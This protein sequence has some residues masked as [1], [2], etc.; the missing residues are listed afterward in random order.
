MSQQIPAIEQLMKW[1][2]KYYRYRIE[3]DGHVQ[4]GDGAMVT[5]SGGGRKVVV[6][7]E[8]IG[9]HATVEDAI[10]QAIKQWHSDESPKKYRV[11]VDVEPPKSLVFEPWH[12]GVSWMIYMTA[13]SEA[14]VN[15]QLQAAYGHPLSEVYIWEQA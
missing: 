6:C 10:I 2:R 5:L 3:T 9:F 12:A 1:D 14:D 15:Q 13:K 8:D 7:A 4:P 11:L